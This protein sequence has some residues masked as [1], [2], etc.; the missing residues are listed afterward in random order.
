MIAYTSAAINWSSNN[1]GGIEN[2]IGEAIDN[3]NTAMENSEID[4]DINLVHSEKVNYT[5]T[6]DDFETDIRRL[7]NRFDGYLEEIHDPRDY[8]GADLV[9]L[10][11]KRDEDHNVGGMAVGPRNEYQLIPDYAFS[12]VS[13]QDISPRYVFT[14]EIGHKFGTGHAKDQEENPGPQLFDH[15]AGWR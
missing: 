10:F 5:E 9:S 2:T 8:H 3:A 4:L 6:G 13:V 14:H 11:V 12:V 1:D 15:S 7:R